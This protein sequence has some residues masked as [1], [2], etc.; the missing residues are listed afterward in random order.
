MA[1][2]KDSLPSAYADSLGEMQFFARTFDAKVIANL[3][4]SGTVGYEITLQ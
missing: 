2:L 4:K 1:P 3:I